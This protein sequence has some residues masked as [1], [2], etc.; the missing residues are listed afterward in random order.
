MVTLKEARPLRLAHG[1]FVSLILPMAALGGDL[2]VA[3][4][5]EKVSIAIPE[6]TQ[7]G[8][9]FRLR[10]KGIKGVRSSYPGDLYC[11]VRV[12]I[13]VRLTEKQKK[14]LRDLENSLKEGGAKHSP[15]ARS[16]MERMKGFF[17]TE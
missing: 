16:F 1:L 11:H 7:N 3:T 4:L 13:P 10:G 14:L 5:T 17:A 8:K 2:E 9:T 6:G 12:E 15:Q